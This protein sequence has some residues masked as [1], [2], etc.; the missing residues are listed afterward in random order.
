MTFIID[1]FQFYWKSEH[2]QVKW[3]KINWDMEI[4]Q[5]FSLY[6]YKVLFKQKALFKWLLKFISWKVL[7]KIWMITVSQEKFLSFDFIL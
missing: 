6:T 1:V 3:S 7:S 2:K 5:Y 4:W